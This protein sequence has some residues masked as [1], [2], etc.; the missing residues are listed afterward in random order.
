LKKGALLSLKNEE[1]GKD[2]NNHKMLKS[3]E[4]STLK[5]EDI[6][7]SNKNEVVKDA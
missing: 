1:H 3:G 4:R 2:S 7:K 6:L 5:I